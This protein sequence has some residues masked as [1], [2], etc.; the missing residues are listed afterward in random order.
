MITNITNHIP[1][2]RIIV[3]LI[4]RYNKETRCILILT[5]RRDHLQIIHEML[6]LQD[7]DSGFY[8]GG[9]SAQQLRDAQEKILFLEHLYG[10]RRYGYT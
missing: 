8:V 5:D 4:E 3:D 1:R 9:M 7:I 10:I 6:K 2:T